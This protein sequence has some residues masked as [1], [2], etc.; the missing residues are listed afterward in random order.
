[1]ERAILDARAELNFISWR[2]SRDTTG[3]FWADSTF[4]KKGKDLAVCNDCLVS[5]LKKELE[6]DKVI[7]EALSL[8][9]HSETIKAL[10][11]ARLSLIEKYLG[12]IRKIEQSK[13]D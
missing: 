13:L 12:I 6:A 2:I 4:T 3:I 11:T 10:T 8:P 1:M 9:K 7:H 5:Q